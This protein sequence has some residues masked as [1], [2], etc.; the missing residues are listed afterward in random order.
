MRSLKVLALAAV[1]GGL[2]AGAARGD[3]KPH[4]LFSDNMVLQQGVELA[5]YGTA[6]PGEE[7]AVKLERKAAGEASAAAASAT[8]DKDGKWLVKLPAQKA[9][10]E[11]ALEVKG[12][13]AVAFKN[14]AVGE[15]W[16]CSGQSNMEWS[17][18]AGETPDKVKEGAANPNLR[19]FTVRKRTAPQPITSQDDLGHFTTWTVS[20]PETVG[21][22][23][24]VGYHFGQKLQKELGVP[25]GLIHSSWGGTPAQAW[26]STEALDADP[27]LKHYADA[28]R[29]AAKGHAAYDQKAA[30]AAYEAAHEK[31][32][33]DAAKA[34][35]DGKP[36]PKEPAKPGA[37]A[38]DLGP[39]T[40]GVLYNAMIHPL[41]GFKV[42]GAIWYQGESNTGRAFEYRTLFP[43]MIE[44]W[45]KRFAC[46]LPF[47]VVQLA[48]FGNGKGNSGGVTYAELRDA[49][50]YT[51]KKLPKVGLAVITD[52]GNETDIHPKPKQP[53][54]ERL[55]LAALG[56]E[57]GKKIG[58]SGPV[59]KEAK[60]E[61]SAATLTFDHVGGGL[62]AKDGDLTGFTAAGADGV[63]H[64][65]KAEI[66]GDTVVVTSDKVEK[67]A[68]VRYGWV[69]FAT[70]TLNLFNKDGLPATPFRTDDAPYTTAPKSK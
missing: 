51:T 64:P 58:F 47:M 12:K 1:V 21:G 54:G 15:V 36:V 66:K 49:Q 67:V 32:K 56:I 35:A 10:T 34:K 41:L 22:F 63:F 20:G 6:A 60:F 23:S 69:N 68:A 45:R 40:P 30:L 50:L 44:D 48:P 62:V 55:A 70:P 9:G 26:A 65:A 37:K 29:A 8:A 59:F 46:D 57:Y 31:W 24:A 5:V 27:A 3:V 4:P 25:V 16:V 17:V 42:K 28:G 53:V 38:P 52:V 13:N 18:N 7:V 19:L 33:A 2:S 11:Y 61:G 14:V 43:A 39:G